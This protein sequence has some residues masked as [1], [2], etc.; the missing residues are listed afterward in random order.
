MLFRNGLR[1]SACGR[2]GKSMDLTLVGE[3]CI[4]LD[5]F[6]QVGWVLN[7]HVNFFSF[8]R[9]DVAHALLSSESLVVF[10]GDEGKGEVVVGFGLCRLCHELHGIDTVWHLIRPT[11]PPT[12]RS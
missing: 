1:A 5:S 3:I 11:L 2:D 8:F 9:G 7:L 4:V 12:I 10:L 6:L